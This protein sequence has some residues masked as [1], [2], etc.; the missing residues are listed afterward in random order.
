LPPREEKEPHESI[1]NSKCLPIDTHQIDS[2]VPPPEASEESKQK[3]KIAV[4]AMLNRV[5]K[6]QVGGDKLRAAIMEEAQMLQSLRDE[7]FCSSFK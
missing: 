1:D 4:D 3:W 2:Y 7:L 5:R 6:M